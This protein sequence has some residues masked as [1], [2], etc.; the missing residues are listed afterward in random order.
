MPEKLKVQP[1]E[2][3]T[4][5]AERLGLPDTQIILSQSAN[6]SFR[7]RP[8]PEMLNPGETLTVPDLQ[9]VKFT[10]ATGKRHKLTI[11]RPK[12]KLRVKLVTFQGKATIATEAEVTPDGEPAEKAS[13]DAGKLE[14][15]LP[16]ACPQ[17]LVK[18][19]SPDEG[20]PD[21]HWRL[22]LGHLV[23]SESDEGALARL[24]NLGY[25]RVV[26]KD[27]DVRERRAAIEEFQFDQGLTLSGKLDDDTKKKLE[28]I[29]G[30]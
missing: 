12:A 26:A 20:S 13:L 10:L 8:H 18:V 9:P 6:S 11:R 23:R 14:A 29:H 30:S 7:D 24:R 16:P 3:L 2:H 19:K 1:G 21:V 22:R 5:I 17:A 4:A 25:Y 28:E 15:K 27:A